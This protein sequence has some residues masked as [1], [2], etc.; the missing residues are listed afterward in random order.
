MSSLKSQTLW[1][2]VPITATMITGLITVRLFL[3]YLSDDNYAIYFYVLSLG[4]VFGFMDLGI[5][6]SVGRYIGMA[7]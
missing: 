3:K 5:G 2:F 4:G 6:C 1:N 7:L